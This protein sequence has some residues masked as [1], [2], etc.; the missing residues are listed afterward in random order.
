M[1]Q[2]LLLTIMMLSLIGC[3]GSGENKAETPPVVIEP[4]PVVPQPPPVLDL[5]GQPDDGLPL[6]NNNTPDENEHFSGGEA[7]T[8]VLNE[9]AFGQSAPAIKN[10]FELDAV[11]K[12]GDH[13]FRSVH[14]GQGPLFNN[15]TCQGCHLKDGRGEVP[16]SPAN[17]MISMLLRIS[18]G[19]GNPDPIYGEQLQTFGVIAG[20][21]SGA[22]AKFNGA[23]DEGLVY[24]EA[25][26]FVEY[27]M[28]TGQFSDGE[29]YELRKPVYKVKDLS[30]GEFNPSVRFSPRV[31]PSVF[32]SGL[33]H[34]I[35][36][37]YITSYA[38]PDDADNDGISG[39][40]VFVTEPISNETQLAR[41]G[42][43]LSTSSVL[44]QASGAYSK[45]MG[46]TNSVDREEPCTAN[47]QVCIEGA[48]LEPNDENDGLD[49]NDVD[50]A[51]VEFYNRLLAVPM[52]RG[53][54]TANNQWD[55]EVVAGRKLFFEANCSGCHIP[56]H[57]TLEA[58]GSLLGDVGLLDIQ[59][60]STPIA[61]LSNQVIYPFTDLLLHDMGGQCAPISRETTAGEMCQAGDDC[62]Y[63][64]RCD[65]LADGLP[66]GDASGSEW[67][68]AP[69]W[70]L[71]LVN[72]V[73]ARATFLHDGRARTI[74]E[75]IL[76]HGGEAEQSK[77]A[78]INMSKVER[79]Q[80]VVFLNSL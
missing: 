75:A 14:K 5:P 29:S 50:L 24:G 64:Q 66:E 78:F 62:I 52:R 10:E 15:P 47:Q 3:G 30:Y 77:L 72:Q 38:D 42:Y 70:G 71:G 1:K 53:F 13:L 19:Q 68:T 44:H 40:A 80:L 23:L 31:S 8:Q 36:E 16:S 33:L 25:Y 56:R 35:P 26:P 43:K 51:Q 17:P 49:L 20:Y 12:S 9:E 55:E 59:E 69:L 48:E 22:L 54:D 27:E 61:A 57:K 6:I 7:T 39:R 2:S 65:G 18:D 76:W 21:P 41:F 37:D 45:D 60:T 73:N 74:S 11:F 63:V 28:V 58:P 34:A 67:R 4:P 32:G 46:I 79:N